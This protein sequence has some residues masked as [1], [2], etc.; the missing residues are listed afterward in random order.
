VSDEPDE[1]QPNRQALA[2]RDRS[3]PGKITGR[4]RAAIEAMVWDGASRAEAALVAGMTDHSVRAALKKSHVLA[5]YRAECEVLRESGRAK[6]L[7]RLEELAAQDENKNAAVAAIKVAEQLGE[8]ENVR[9]AG[10][11]VMP[12][13]VI[14]LISGSPASPVARDITPRELPA[15]TVIDAQPID[16]MISNTVEPLAQ[17]IDDY[18]D[19]ELATQMSIPFV[20]PI[21]EPLARGGGEERPGEDRA[22]CEYVHDAP[23]S[24]QPAFG[25]GRLAPASMIGVEEGKRQNEPRARSSTRFRSR[26][27]D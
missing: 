12:G 3:R 27:G 13:L 24:S 23:P 17:P 6:R 14:R 22:A 8:D 19:A 11:T 15:P 21:D 1:P 7:H 20:E 4:L 16:S 5:Y 18:V 10:V 2:A 26:R 9:R 25:S